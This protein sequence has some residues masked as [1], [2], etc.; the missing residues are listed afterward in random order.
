MYIA[1][2]TFCLYS[3][4]YAFRKPFTVASFGELRMLGLPYQSVLIISQVIGYMLS[5]FFGIRFI[6]SMKRTGRWKTS[7]VLMASAWL[8]LL[9]FA[10]LPDWAGIPCFLINGYM[11]GFMWGIV[12][13]YAE[14]RRSTDLIG[15]VMAISFIFAGGFTR[16]AGKW[17]MTDYGVT[18]RWMP[19]ITGMLFVI[20]LAIFIFLLEKVPGPDEEDIKLRVERKSM[21]ASDR[22]KII[23]KFSAGIIVLAIIYS[24][25]TIIRD[26]RDNF[27]G[28]IWSDLGYAND[29]SIFARSETR[30]SAGILLMMALLVLVRSNIKAFMI[31][32]VLVITGFLLAGISSYLFF[33]GKMSGSWWMQLVGLGLYMAYIPFNAIFFDRMIA[34]FRISGNVGFLIYLTDAFGYLGSVAVMI[35]KE[36]LTLQITWSDFYSR[37]VILFSIIGVAGTIYSIYY[38]SLKYKRLIVDHAQIKGHSSGSG[39]SRIGY[40]TGPQQ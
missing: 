35:F 20:P 15:S 32:H 22:K 4:V 38:F 34:A 12:F 30:I 19:F 10:V 29:F 1:V 24:F 3:S 8:T 36:G 14:G 39:Y 21:N 25:L 40:G 33:I 9:L 31:I 6:S 18:A 23:A 13:S 26:L 5:K 17:L 16:S 28:N 2:L 37:S 11:L 7:V 27:M